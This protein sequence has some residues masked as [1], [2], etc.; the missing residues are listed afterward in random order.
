MEEK[1]K[2][3]KKIGQTNILW[4]LQYRLSYMVTNSSSSWSQQVSEKYPKFRNRQKRLLE[5]CSE[6][7]WIW[8][9]VN[10]LIF[11]I[12]NCCRYMGGVHIYGVYG[13]FWNRHT[14]YFNH[15]RVNEVFLTSCVYALCYKQFNY[16]ILGIWTCTINLLFKIVTW[17]CYQITDLI[18]SNDIFVYINH[19]HF[20]SP[21]THYPCQLLVATILPSI[22]PS[23]IF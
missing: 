1:D 3:K 2:E 20:S 11:Y 16:T 15:I 14:M 12:C 4:F 23:S 18:H 5:V 7:F 22:S 17:L 10:C 6:Q 9:S 19:P 21:P 8:H 13:I